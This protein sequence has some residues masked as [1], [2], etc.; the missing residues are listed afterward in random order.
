MSEVRLLGVVELLGEEGDRVGLGPPQQRCVLAALAMTPGR[1]V[2]VEA[3]VETVWRDH[4][5]E[6]VREVLYTYVSRLRRVLR[7][8]GAPAGVL[9]RGD[10]GYV[11]DVPAEWVDVH[12]AR[13]LA[14][15]ARSG[16]VD[17]Q[18]A[19][20]LLREAAG[21]WW[22]TPL[23]GLKG[24]WA[25]RVRVGLV[26][27]LVTLLTDRFEIELELGRHAEVVS[28]L[29]SAVVEHP[30]AEPLTGQLMVAL[31]RSG[32]Q[33]DALAAYGRVRR[34]LVEELGDEPGSGLRRLHE[35][36][37]RHDPTLDHQ[38]PADAAGEPDAD[39][40]AGGGGPAV[41]PAQLPA[42]VGGFTGR[43]DQ[44]ARLDA[45]VGGGTAGITAIVGTAGVGKT[46][47]A[48]HWAH[49]ANDRFPDGQL[50]V[51]LRGFDEPGKALA[52]AH[53]LRDFL[54]AFQVPEERMPADVDALSGVFRSVLAGRRVLLVLDN[55]RDMAQV[56][57]LLPGAPGCLAVVTSRNQLPGL[58]A[59]TGASQLTLGLFTPDEARQMLVHRLGQDRLRGQPQAV[60]EIAERCARLPL[61]LAIVAAHAATRPGFPLSAIAAQLREADDGL[62]PLALAY[63]DTAADIQA[64]FSWSYRTLSPE[65]ARLF[66]LIG[67]HAGPDLA[68]GAAA[69][70]AG[71]P[72]PGTRPLL[73][74]LTR[75][76]LITEHAPGRFTLHDLL[77]D[78]A[79]RLARD[80]EPESERREAVHRII[81]YYLHSTHAAL[82]AL[83]ISRIQLKDA[84]PMRSTTMP[85]RFTDASQAMNWLAAER[86]TLM[87][88]V[89]LA[90]RTGLDDH[91]IRLCRRLSSYLD[92]QCHWHDYLELQHIITP[93]TRRLG[94]A[95]QQGHSLY[96]L[97]VACVRL[98]RFQQARE[99]FADA[100]DLFRK[101][102]DTE[103]QGHVHNALAFL[104]AQEGAYAEALRCA[105][106]SLALYQAVENETGQGRALNQV[107]WCHILLGEHER[108][109]SCGREALALQERIGDRYGVAQTLRTVGR[110]HQ[111]LGDWS[112][113]IACH[114]QAL[115]ELHLPQVIDRLTVC[116]TLID[117]GDAHRGAGETG[118][119][120]EAWERALR[121]FDE[122]HPSG[123]ELRSRLAG[124]G[125]PPP[126]TGA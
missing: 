66:R 39:V 13:G 52:P 125:P 53:V 46:T 64:V 95:V 80:R 11:L 96:A 22:G 87:A 16:E 33:A 31:Y 9:R 1:P 85:E 54:R 25:Q 88:A 90:V 82:V 123:D 79:A 27:E 36:I 114:Q 76:N 69:G 15:R 50:Y 5:P 112:Q 109:L 18:G 77:R 47:L 34:L 4:P 61:A 8:A 108:A 56:R 40:E 94:D 68:T 92:R 126:P 57:P 105:R 65:A 38:P 107:A 23:S 20:E 35:R 44:L 12:R 101:E 48:V 121:L 70:L 81:D 14:R 91:A 55:A 89:D 122:P 7:Q 115:D 28:G 83:G 32:R 106:E 102:D 117:L 84:G 104:N 51:N 43:A 97:A 110:A 59:A 29:S 98:G 41:R 74:E 60:T 10:G 2:A 78:Y 100:L 62:D 116:W 17:A 118:P 120:R 73:A 37:L 63:G 58:V 26:E 99:Y 111:D 30:L 45:T 42:D 6:N 93:A 67:L 3:L 113:A 21:L 86:R 75:E 103:A 24:E 19:V 119:A 124:H 71:L 49:G 72:V